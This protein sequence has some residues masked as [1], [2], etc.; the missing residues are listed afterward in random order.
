MQNR[1]SRRSEKNPSSIQKR[2][3]STTTSAPCSSMN[4][5]SPVTRLYWCIAY[6]MSALMW[7][8]AVPAAYQAEASSPVIVRHG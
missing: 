4:A 8:C 7:Y 3:V 6:A 5:R 2:A 1:P